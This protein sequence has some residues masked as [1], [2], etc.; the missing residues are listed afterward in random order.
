MARRWPTG[1]VPCARA[2]GRRGSEGR[3]AQALRYA[4]RLTAD[5]PTLETAHRRLMRL[6]HLRG[7]QA[8]ALAAYERF[9][10]RLER[11]L[12]ATP[13]AQTRDLLR[14]IETS[15]APPSGAAAPQPV[16]IL[17]PPRLIG[18]DA[19]WA[20]LEAAA[21]ERRSVLVC[22]DAG[23]GKSRLLGDFAA[24]RKGTVFVKAR[25]G[26]TSDPYALLA[27]LLRDVRAA[28]PAPLQPWA[29]A[30]LARLLP[31]LGEPAPGRLEPLRLRQAVIQALGHAA[32]AGIGLV[33]ADDLHAADLASIELLLAVA[34][35]EQA[36]TPCW[37][38]GARRGEL[39][40]ALAEWAVPC[41]ADRP[42]MLIL[43]NLDEPGVEALLRSLDLPGLDARALAPAFMQRTGGNPLFVLETLRA[44]VARGGADFPEGADVLPL[45]A[46]VTDL[47]AHRLHRLSAPALALA[48]VAALAG[49]DFDVPLAA[50]VLDCHPLDLAGPW[51]ELE[52]G[53]VIQDGTFVHDLVGDAARGLIAPDRAADLHRRIATHLESDGAA[54]TRIAR[55]WRDA[56]QWARAA[57][58]FARAAE[59]AERAS[60]KAIELDLWEAAGACFE[61]A[62]DRSGEFRA[63]RRSVSALVGLRPAAEAARR[64]E[65]LCALAH[66]E[67][68]RADAL[69]A[70][71]YVASVHSEWSTARGVGEAARQLARR[72][73]QPVVECAAGDIVAMAHAHAGE[74][75]AAIALMNET[76]T[77]AR[78]CCDEVRQGQYLAEFSRILAM[79]G[80]RVQALQIKGEAASVFA[81][82]ADWTELLLMEGSQAVD[83]IHLGWAHEGL[84]HAERA[85]ALIERVGSRT[86]MHAGNVLVPL[87]AL[88]AHLGDFRR[89][90]DALDAAMACFRHTEHA[91]FRVA[92]ENVTIAL[93][94]RLGQFARA[95]RMADSD[96]PERLRDARG[97][98]LTLLARL[99]HAAGNSGRRYLDE[100]LKLHAG[101]PVGLAPTALLARLELSRELPPAA[102][103]AT[104]TEV[105]RE[106]MRGEWLGYAA[107]ARVR[108][109][110]CLAA[111][112]PRAAADVMGRV[113]DDL[114]RISPVDSYLP[115]AWWV[116]HRAFAAAGDTPSARAALRTARDWVMRTALPTVPGAYRD[117]F[118]NRNPVNRAILTTAGRVLRD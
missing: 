41:A 2:G 69:W 38:M 57:A 110:D 116:A 55:H 45:P 20:E 28:H 8:A 22:G 72:T 19:Q 56:G 117:S 112:D 65:R 114:P 17:R 47:I 102:A 52:D 81:R 15:K 53:H 21:A 58:Q 61:R 70:Q 99:E 91:P 67:T 54:P 14:T 66:D 27:R 30:E 9:R 60:N 1:C 106:A 32:E 37:L 23:I 73:H 75:D 83:C 95:R 51:R 104:C 34:D 100:V 105:E 31:E 62:G 10:V 103:L 113:L 87:G 109:A 3:I 25:V 92:T 40:P 29:Q 85:C 93:L 79:T 35:A 74:F 68:R 77:L 12:G 43:D 78:T 26:E 80:R 49:Q 13:D 50:Q 76:M 44:W 88:A 4:E 7:D 82:T 39:P 42:R 94:I 5:E 18:R 24:H 46:R 59:I 84:A 89:G 96:V 86:G 98:R 48:Q 111:D 36:G 6:H 63:L 108:Q 71:A 64:I 16:A 97:R 11:E 118:L 107:A 33:V 90:L 115:E 101:L